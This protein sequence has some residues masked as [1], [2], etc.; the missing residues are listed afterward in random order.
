MLDHSEFALYKIEQTLTSAR[1]SGVLASVTDREAL[2]NIFEKYH[3]DIV[4]HA[5]AYKHV[6]IVE[7]NIKQSIINNVLGTK[8]VIDVAISNQIEKLVLISS[9]KAVRPSNIMG[10]TKR[11]GELYLQN[12]ISNKTQMVA[13][14]FGNVLGSSGS[15]IPLFEKQIKAG[16][17]VTVTHPEVTRYFMLI[18][19]ACELVLQAAAL[20]AGG[21]IFILDMGK[22]VKILSLAEQMIKLSHSSDIAVKFIGL[23]AGEKLHEELF[24]DEHGKQTPYPSIMIA[25]KDF[26]DIKALERDISTLMTSSDKIALLKKIVPEFNADTHLV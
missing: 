8:Y 12:V 14:R 3:I 25:K 7:A 23:R 17:P 22:P 2:E 19:E 18:S 20:G 4:I 1:V 26:Y 9:D 21:E 15:V 13:V 16:G 5:A 11:I 10:T 24:L 6:P